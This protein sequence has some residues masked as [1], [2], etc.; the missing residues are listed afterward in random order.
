MPEEQAPDSWIS[1]G[2]KMKHVLQALE[3]QTRFLCCFRKDVLLRCSSLES[4]AGKKQTGSRAHP[5]PLALHLPLAP[6]I[7]SA[8]VVQ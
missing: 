2:H 3:K 1:E 4:L 5:F 8:S 6:R 7:G